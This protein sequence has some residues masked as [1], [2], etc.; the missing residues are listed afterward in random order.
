M[1]IDFHTF[2]VFYTKLTSVIFFFSFLPHISASMCRTLPSPCSSARSR[3]NGTRPRRTVSISQLIRASCVSKVSRSS[4]PTVTPLL[5][6]LLLLL[7]P[8]MTVELLG[9]VLGTAIQGQIVGM[10]NA[11]C[12]PGPAELAAEL[13]N[14]TVALNDSEPVISLEHTVSRRSSA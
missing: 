14:A 13:S 3:K 10:A 5:S 11:P 9:T 7:L 2:L 6:L 1:E 4:P 12:L 8:G